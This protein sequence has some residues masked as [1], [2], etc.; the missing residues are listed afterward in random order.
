MSFRP[1]EDLRHVPGPTDTQNDPIILKYRLLK[2]VVTD[3]QIEK[4]SFILGSK[5][6]STHL[7]CFTHFTGLRVLNR[8]MRELEK[9]PIG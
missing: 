6:R 1:Y 3:K 7:L 9:G 8:A 2:H 4:K 5:T